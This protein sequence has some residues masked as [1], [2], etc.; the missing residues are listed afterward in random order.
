MR[1]R[2]F[3]ALAP[4]IGYLYY[5]SSSKK[6]KKTHTAEEAPTV[7]DHE[8]IFYRAGAGRGRCKIFDLKLFDSGEVELNSIKNVGK[9]GLH[10]FNITGEQVQALKTIIEEA[11]FA[12]IKNEYFI[13]GNKGSQ[14]FE[15]IIDEKSTAFH[16]KKAPKSL[17]N[18]KDALDNLIEV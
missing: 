15:I 9:P 16:K 2:Y 10:T 18:I 12:S 13:K 14:Q 1:L 6:S 5:L 7:D 4:V 17:K 3:L 8:I 11:N